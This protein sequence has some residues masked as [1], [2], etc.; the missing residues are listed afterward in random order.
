M[1]RPGSELTIEHLSLTNLNYKPYA[2]PTRLAPVPD[3]RAHAL[4]LPA[5][6]PL[7][8]GALADMISSDEEE[9]D[10]L[11]P[12]ANPTHVRSPA[13]TGRG[14]P[15]PASSSS[16]RSNSP[17]SSPTSSP[18]AP[19]RFMRNPTPA[20]KGSAAPDAGGNDSP[21]PRLSSLPDNAFISEAQASSDLR[22]L[23]LAASLSPREETAAP[24]HQSS[25]CSPPP[26]AELAAAELSDG[27]GSIGGDG[28]RAAAAELDGQ[29]GVELDDQLAEETVREAMAVGL[30]L[31]GQLGVELDGQLGV[32]FSD[33]E[34]GAAAD[35]VGAPQVEQ[36]GNDG[37]YL[38]DGDAGDGYV[39]EPARYR[40][41]E[42]R[43][44]QGA[45]DERILDEWHQQVLDEPSES[46][47]QD[48]QVVDERHEQGS[49]ERHEQGS[50]ERHGDESDA[51][52]DQIMDELGELEDELEASGAH[53]AYEDEQDRKSPPSQTPDQI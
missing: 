45:D 43:Q 39:E 6:C 18:P 48:E 51:D 21:M 41:V 17:P 29:L 7:V 1:S 25:S 52:E 50:E 4:G 11:I 16:V 42:Q 14:K 36:D 22:S 23:P 30:E 5:P 2:T 47:Q 27:G 13:G 32:D 3:A 26:I 12:P 53:G 40:R 8:A 10:N 35:G 46:S 19:P 24:P 34:G 31:D 15:P 33:S 37:Q 44:M 20:A 49:E 28:V 9:D 38:S